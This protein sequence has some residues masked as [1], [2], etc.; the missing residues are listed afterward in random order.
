MNQWRARQS[1]RRRYDL[2]VLPRIEQ[3]ARRFE[4]VVYGRLDYAGETYDLYALK[5]RA[6]DP[7][8]PTAL[9]TGGVHGNETSGVV[10]ALQ[11]LETCAGDYARRVNLLPAPCV[12]PWAYERIN[13]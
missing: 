9:V 12:S 11:F 2:D 1:R 8:L 13:R 4:T 6:W 10:G 5:S 3:L 7:A